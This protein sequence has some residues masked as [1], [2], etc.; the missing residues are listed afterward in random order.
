MVMEYAALQNMAGIVD[1]LWLWERMNCCSDRPEG[2][3][4]RKLNL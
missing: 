3:G 4:F 1:G 2:L